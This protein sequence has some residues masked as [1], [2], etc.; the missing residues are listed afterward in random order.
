MLRVSS[1]IPVGCKIWFLMSR[2]FCT[3]DRQWFEPGMIGSCLLFLPSATFLCSFMPLFWLMTIF[4]HWWVPT[5]LVASCCQNWWSIPACA[6]CLFSWSLWHFL[7]LEAPRF[8]ISNDCFGHAYGFHL[9]IMFSIFV[10]LLGQLHWNWN[11]TDCAGQAASFEE[12]FVWHVVWP[13]WCQHIQ[14]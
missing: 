7:L 2:P 11:K 13:Y 4:S 1:S 5:V 8:W 14:H 10:T 3:S 12:F 6:R 9:C